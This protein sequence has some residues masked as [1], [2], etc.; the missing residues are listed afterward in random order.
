MHLVAHQLF[1]LPPKPHIWFCI[2]W[3]KPL[4]RL[5]LTQEFLFP[6]IA[7]WLL[8]GW[9]GGGNEIMASTTL[10]LYHFDL[11]LK[12]KILF[13]YISRDEDPMPL[14]WHSYV[15]ALH[16]YV[17]RGLVHDSSWA[18]QFNN[19]SWFASACWQSSK[20][21]TRNAIRCTVRIQESLKLWYVCKCKWKYLL[22][23]TSHMHFTIL[24]S[25]LLYLPQV[26]R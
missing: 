19:I 16:N 6:I 23:W 10:H 26:I 22:L 4:V 24:H 2:I 18:L 15:T 11:D 25:E 12:I 21:E 9:G 17:C 1:S 20:T 13:V 8:N 5:R 3:P 7:L 14:H